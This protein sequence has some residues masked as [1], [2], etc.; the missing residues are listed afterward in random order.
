MENDCYQARF[1]FLSQRLIGLNISMDLAKYIEYAFNKA[2]IEK[3][4][5]RLHPAEVDN[6]QEYNEMFSLPNEMWELV[7]YRYINDCKVLITINSSAAFSPFKLYNIEPYVI[8]IYKVVG[9]R[10]EELRVSESIVE[11]LKSAYSDQSK[12]FVPNTEEELI[13]ILSKI[14]EGQNE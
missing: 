6:S 12:I 5:Y 1:I 11:S 4:C 8:F 14:R 10:S 3:F 2:G 13:E 9:L 7:C